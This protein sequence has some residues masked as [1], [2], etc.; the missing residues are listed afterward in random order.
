MTEWKKCKGK[1]I[2]A[3]SEG[4]PEFLFLLFFYFFFGTQ[5][6]VPPSTLRFVQYYTM[7]LQR[8]RIIVVDAGFEPGTSAPEV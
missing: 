5:V 1:T 7:I 2:C 3:Q 8:I 4:A 6:E